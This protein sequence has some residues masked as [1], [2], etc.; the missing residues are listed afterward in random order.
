MNEIERLY[1]YL[2]TS[3]FALAV[4]G[5]GIS[6]SSG[7]KDMDQMDTLEI[8]QMSF[9]P[10]V[11]LH[12]KRSYRLLEKHFLQPISE[13]G[14]SMTH[15]V[16]ADLEKRGLLKGIVTTNIDHLHSLAGSQHVAEIQGSYA[17]NQ[18]RKC[19]TVYQG[20]E[21]WQQGQVPRCQQCGGLIEAFPVYSH[22]GVYDQA[23][24]KALEWTRK[25]DLLLIIGS[26]GNYG[27]YLRELPP[28]TPI[29][30]INPQP[31][32]FDQFASLT[33]AKEADE[34][35]VALQTLLANDAR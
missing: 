22:V 12:P 24:Q 13:H 3:Q 25:A 8:L 4:T 29:V 2:R 5:A 18:C 6:N 9:E 1:H 27:D 28:T 32:Q 11:R 26:K 17:V 31:T 33:I 35:F 34:V 15:Q 14:P 20:L 21:I 30:Q 7:I 23:Y 16:L 10:L 19:Q